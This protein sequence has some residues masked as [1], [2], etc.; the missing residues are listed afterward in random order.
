MQTLIYLLVKKD[1]ENVFQM[2]LCVLLALLE[3]KNTM[4]LFQV[5]LA[6]ITLEEVLFNYLDRYLKKRRELKD[7][8]LIVYEKYLQ[9]I[10]NLVIKNLKY[11]EI[12]KNINRNNLGFVN[13]YSNT[14]TTNTTNTSSIFNSYSDNYEGKLS[15]LTEFCLNYLE[16][17]Y[18]MVKNDMKSSNKNSNSII[19]INNI[20]GVNNKTMNDSC[21][22]TKYQEKSSNID[23]KNKLKLLKLILDLINEIVKKSTSITD[24]IL[25]SSNST[26][27][28]INLNIDNNN[29]SENGNSNSSLE[30]NIKIAQHTSIIEIL[31]FFI[32]NT[33]IFSSI[34][35][36][37]IKLY[38]NL[39]YQSNKEKEFYFDILE[40]RK[41]HVGELKTNKFQL[42]TIMIDS[43]KIIQVCV[44]KLKKKNSL[45]VSDLLINEFKELQGNGVNTEIEYRNIFDIECK[46]IIK[47]LKNNK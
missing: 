33:I 25:Y 44:E 12:I 29:S 19:N 24:R 32:S 34:K 23:Y 41:S 46:K 18:I 31:E 4:F 39:I 6:N 10:L 36:Y 21:S 11:M 9:P 45:L 5:S 7:N 22:I 40:Q 27:Q 16:T 43:L 17:T 2:T 8:E 42:I 20:S 26:S 15:F 35:E 38:Y 14:N 37:S 30:T 3:T 13:N 47:Y 28:A 1:N